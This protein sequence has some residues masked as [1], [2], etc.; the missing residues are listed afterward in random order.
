MSDA[1]TTA[2][3]LRPVPWG[4]AAAFWEGVARGKL[5]VPRCPDTG[6]LFFPPTPVSPYGSHRPPDWVPVSGRG[7][8]WSFIVPHPPLMAQFAD[9][10]P[11]PVAVVELDED[12]RVRLVGPVVAAPGAH[13]DSLDPGT[14]SIGQRVVVDLPAVDGDEAVVPRWIPQAE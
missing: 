7:R 8:I 9:L 14:L 11:F 1:R 3:I 13:L 12:R 4:D 6:R 5:R 2:V 10:R